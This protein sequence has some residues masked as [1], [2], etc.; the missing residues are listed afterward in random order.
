MFSCDFCE[1]SKNAIFTEHLGTAVSKYACKNTVICP[2]FLVW[3]F[4]GKAK[5]SNSFERIPRKYA[6]TVPF[7]KI[8]SNCGI[9]CSGT[10]R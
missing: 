10:N 2:N 8:S 1:I 3:K 9:L 5:F 6:K 7:H 4:C